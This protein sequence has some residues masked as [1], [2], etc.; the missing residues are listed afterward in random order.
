MNRSLGLLL[1]LG[2]IGPVSA[3]PSDVQGPSEA[4]PRLSAVVVG[5]GV[6]H[7]VFTSVDG[8]SSV[9]VGEG[10]RIGPFAVT[11]ITVGRVQLVGPQ[12][13]Y[14]ISPTPHADVRASL[15]SQVADRLGDTARRQAEA[16]NDK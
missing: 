7:A 10:E 13:A 4:L 11:S 14:T 3:Q 5:N 1:A 8:L 16:D 2:A 15:A 9:T 6:R 12:G